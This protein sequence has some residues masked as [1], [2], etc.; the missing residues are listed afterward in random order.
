MSRNLAFLLPF[1]WYKLQSG[2]IRNVPLYHPG[3]RQ[4]RDI[5]SLYIIDR[6][7]MTFHTFRSVPLFIYFHSKFSH[8]HAY[9]SS[10]TQCSA[11]YSNKNIFS[12]RIWNMQKYRAYITFHSFHAFLFVHHTQISN[13]RWMKWMRHLPQM[14]VFVFMIQGKRARFNWKFLKL[15]AFYRREYALRSSWRVFDP[16]SIPGPG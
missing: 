11:Y 7:V 14:L 5:T 9:S 8:F 6:H 1:F 10:C 13:G 4:E 3:R 12:F 2:A 15:G 16:N